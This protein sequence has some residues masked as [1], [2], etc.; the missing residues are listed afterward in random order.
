MGTFLAECEGEITRD[1]IDN[2]FAVLRKL[3]VMNFTDVAGREVLLTKDVY[4][5]TV[6]ISHELDDAV[7][8]AVE[9][10]KRNANEIRL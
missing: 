5:N 9:L 2:T 6:A 3:E 1:D 4:K 7:A 8:S 10:Y